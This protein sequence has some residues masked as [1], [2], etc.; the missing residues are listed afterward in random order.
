MF[1]FREFASLQMAK[2][3]KA[4]DVEPTLIDAR[5]HSVDALKLWLRTTARDRLPLAVVKV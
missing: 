1:K 5:Q 3:F 2:T 4:L